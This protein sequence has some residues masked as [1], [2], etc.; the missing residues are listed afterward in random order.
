MLE[1]KDQLLT[2]N[3]VDVDIIIAILYILIKTCSLWIGRVL[4]RT[5][6]YLF[7]L[8]KEVKFSYLF[9][10]ISLIMLNLVIMI[11]LI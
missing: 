10:K 3:F 4:E 8:N 2:N 1:P 11:L 7:Y 6:I 5:V 9:M